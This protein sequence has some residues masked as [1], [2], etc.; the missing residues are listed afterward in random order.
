[1]YNSIAVGSEILKT[2]LPI[3]KYMSGL[4]HLIIESRSHYYNTS[5][6]FIIYCLMVVC[7]LLFFSLFVNNRTIAPIIIVNT[8]KW[9][10][11]LALLCFISSF[12]EINTKLFLNM[13]NVVNT[14][15]WKHILVIF[16]HKS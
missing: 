5:C 4:S 2:C 3:A 14:T 7:P 8:T 13:L 16:Y 9:K 11:V 12:Y 15:K 10:H 6:F 1:M